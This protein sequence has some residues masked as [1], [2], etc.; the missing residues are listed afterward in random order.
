[1]TAREDDTLTR[2]TAPRRPTMRPIAVATTLTARRTGSNQGTNFDRLFNIH[3][4]TVQRLRVMPSITWCCCP[5]CSCCIKFA[6]KRHKKAAKRAR[7]TNGATVTK[8]PAAC[9]QF[10]GLSSSVHSVADPLR[11]AVSRPDPRRPT[12]SWSSSTAT[13]QSNTS[14]TA[15]LLP[16]WKDPPSSTTRRRALE[17]APAA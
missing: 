14:S 16:R 3:M 1:M 13:A 7:A 11:R 5:S 12:R 2:M 8:K 4:L 15:T 17:R 6:G 10:G 9:A